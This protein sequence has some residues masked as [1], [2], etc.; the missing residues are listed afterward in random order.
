MGRPPANEA[1]KLDTSKRV[2]PTDG[3]RLARRRSKTNTVSHILAILVGCRA[4]R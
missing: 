2:F 1:K 4:L 3:V